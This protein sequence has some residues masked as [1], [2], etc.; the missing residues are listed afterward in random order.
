MAI[1]L[2]VGVKI[3]SALRTI[4][5]FS[6]NFGPRFSEIIPKLTFDRELLTIEEE[7]ASAVY[8]SADPDI[9]KHL[10]V[11]LRAEYQ[12]H[13]NETVIMCAALVEMDHLG[14]PPGIA[15]VQHILQLDSQAKRVR[16]LDQ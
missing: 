11:I 6:T 10:A 1:K 8:R 12:P 15:A 4:T 5:H 2:S 14:S 9:S 7:P 13:S 3:S 16:F